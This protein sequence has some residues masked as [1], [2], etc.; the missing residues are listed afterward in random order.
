[1]HWIQNERPIEYHV[2]RWNNSAF[3][4]HDKTD[5]RKLLGGVSFG[6]GG[7]GGNE[8]GNT[9]GVQNLQPSY[10]H[11]N[12][13]E[14]G[15]TAEAGMTGNILGNGKS[16]GGLQEAAGS[17]K[18]TVSLGRVQGEQIPAHE[19]GM[20]AAAGTLFA[21]EADG[22]NKISDVIESEQK[23]SK[24]SIDYRKYMHKMQNGVQAFLQG[25]RSKAGKERREQPKK[26]QNSATG[27]VTKED[28]Y[29]VQINTAYLLDSYNKYGERSTLGK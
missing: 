16:G 24:R 25:M 1:M 22:E 20:T 15:G 21:A 8:T 3:H 9:T 18:D 7:A 5:Q 12:G 19:A 4:N 6:G 28:V 2:V 29:E 10:S 23:K 13:L 17:G 27:H 11:V 26:K 14:L